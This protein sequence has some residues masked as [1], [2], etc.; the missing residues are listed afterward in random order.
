[1]DETLFRLNNKDGSYELTIDKTDPSFVEKLLTP[2]H[3]KQYEAEAAHMVRHVKHLEE[4][5]S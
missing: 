5:L 3:R 4:V 2:E 1:M